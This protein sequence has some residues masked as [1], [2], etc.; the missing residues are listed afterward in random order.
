MIRSLTTVS[1][2]V[3]CLVIGVGSVESVTVSVTEAVPSDEGDPTIWLPLTASPAGRPEADQEYG[4]VPPLAVK[5]RSVTN[6]CDGI[7]QRRSGD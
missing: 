1:G 5:C 7:R 2:N 4:K 6:P 3:T